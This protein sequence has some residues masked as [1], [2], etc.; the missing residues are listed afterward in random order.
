MPARTLHLL[1][2]PP[3]S[4]SKSKWLSYKLPL[5]A[6]HS[7]N[8]QTHL[9]SAK[10]L[11]GEIVTSC[12]LVVIAQSMTLSTPVQPHLTMCSKSCALQNPCQFSGA[13]MKRYMV[14]CL[15]SLMSEMRRK[16]SA[17]SKAAKGRYVPA[18]MK[19]NRTLMMIMNHAMSFIC[20]P[21][22]NQ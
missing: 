4:N 13:N 5:W 15:S 3:K 16:E 21:L 1:I 17:L 9:N 19:S 11:L 10:V 8:P 2:R 6:R 7:H 18:P 12:L 22:H 14:N 20:L